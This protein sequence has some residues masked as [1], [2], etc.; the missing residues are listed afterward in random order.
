MRQPVSISSNGG[1]GGGETLFSH[2]KNLLNL[3]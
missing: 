1:A 2:V 3:Y